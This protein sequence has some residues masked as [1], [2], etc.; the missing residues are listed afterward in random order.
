MIFLLSACSHSNK[1]F[2][3]ISASKTG[4]DFNNYLEESDEMNVLNYTYF[5]NGGGVATGDLNNDGLPDI[6][7]TGNM[8]RNKIFINKGNMQFDD[9]TSTSGIAEKQGW[10]TGVTLVDINSDGWLD[11]YI[12]R[13]ADVNPERRTNLLFINNKDL[14]FSEKASEYGLADQGYS[15]QAAFFD[16]DRDGDLDVAVINHSLKKYTTGVSDNPELRKEENPFFASK[17][18]RNDGGRFLDVSKIAGIT[19]NVLSF[20]LGIVV[21]DF[22]ND[23]WPDFFISNDFNE[24]DYLFMNQRDGTFKEEGAKM[25]SQHSL[26]S[27]G[28]D[29]ADIDNDGFTDLVTLDMLPESNFDQ[30]MHSGA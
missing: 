27:M 14:T 15:T 29:A 13:S 16:Y 8:V 22:N 4:I 23:S 3:E 24:A 19:S 18:Y 2:E 10:C 25:L 11:I 6:V 12:C 9:I 17:L 5:Y 21:S 7:F 26:F 28:T 1:F 20:G 30:K